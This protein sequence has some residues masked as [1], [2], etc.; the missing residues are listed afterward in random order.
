LTGSK[1]AIREMFE[2]VFDQTYGKPIYSDKWLWGA[3]KIKQRTP[4]QALL[5]GKV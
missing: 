1:Q 3:W 2:I 5:W 4:S